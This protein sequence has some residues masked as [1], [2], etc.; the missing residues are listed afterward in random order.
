MERRTACPD[1]A[2]VDAGP[3]IG[4]HSKVLLGP[5]RDEADP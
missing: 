1:A 4:Y 5:T 3:L 2:A